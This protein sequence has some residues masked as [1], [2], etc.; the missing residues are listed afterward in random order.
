MRVIHTFFHEAAKLGTSL[1]H[2]LAYFT[3]TRIESQPT[4]KSCSPGAKH[5][6]GSDALGELHFYGVVCGV[7]DEL[8]GERRELLL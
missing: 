3:R 2:Y 8:G 7:E 5:E 4:T 1:Q 6:G